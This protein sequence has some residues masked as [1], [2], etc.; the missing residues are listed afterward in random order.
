M[1]LLRS[2]LFNLLFFI[3]SATMAV[4]ILP[5]ALG[6]RRILMQTVQW[7]AR[8]IVLLLRVVCDIRVRVT[9]LEHL[10]PGPALVA[11][12]HQSAF[13]TVVWLWL[14]PNPVYVLKR[15]L[16]HIPVYGWLA[17]RTG[18]IPVDRT[19]GATAMR[20]LLRAGTTAAGEGRQIVIFP[21]GTR[22]APGAR[23]PYL[24]G[25]VALAAATGVPVVPAATDSGLS[26]GRRSFLKR[27]GTITVALLP[28]LPPG[29]N[30]AATMEALVGAIE[31]ETDRLIAARGVDKSVD[32][33][34]SIPR[35]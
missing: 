3:G 33:I 13:D 29:L 6:P 1:I 25:V 30:R 35:S 11:A 9:G 2:V 8:G 27:P 5:L 31:P 7:W 21:E 26:W 32:E 12:K 22:V 17:R 10:P 23:V 18:M 34:W 15:E 24:P 20:Q 14:L 19:A 16:L 4:L 28:P